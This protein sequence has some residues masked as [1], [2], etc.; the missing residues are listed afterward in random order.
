M[1]DNGKQDEPVDDR[2]DCP[3][4]VGLFLVAF[5]QLREQMTAVLG[6]EDGPGA[7]G[8]KVSHEQ[9]FFPVLDHSRHELVRQ[10][11]GGDAA[12]D[13]D[14]E[15]EEHQA[16]VGEAGAV[17]VVELAPGHDGANV[18]EAA[19]VEEHVDARVDLVVAAFRLGEVVT[20]PVEGVAGHEAGEEV[21]GPDGAAGADEEHAERGRE[22][23]VRLS[24]DP[25]AI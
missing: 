6:V 1:D 3:G 8:P 18:H 9:G 4:Q 17:G 20:V 5:A 16:S 12:E 10:E 24:V 7:N 25:F 14:H 21:V 19:K 2:A 15:A 23:D 22:K 13:E 11:D